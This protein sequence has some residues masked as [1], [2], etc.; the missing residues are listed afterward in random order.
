M[1]TEL[2]TILRTIEKTTLIGWCIMHA[3]H[4]EQY[5]ELIISL[6]D[7]ASH[8]PG[9][10]V[11]VIGPEAFSLVINNSNELIATHQLNCNFP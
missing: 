8:H 10:L 7:M 11:D 6:E 2:I 9:M 4:N 3:L 1:I 5:D